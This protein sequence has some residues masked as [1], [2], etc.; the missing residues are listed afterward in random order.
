[1]RANPDG[2]ERGA[3][4]A[5]YKHPGSYVQPKPGRYGFSV[6]R[7]FWS[8]LVCQVC[9][10]WCRAWRQR[11]DPLSLDPPQ[12]LLGELLCT[13]CHRPWVSGDSWEQRDRAHQTAQDQRHISGRSRCVLR[14]LQGDWV[15]RRLQFPI[16]L[17]KLTD[18]LSPFTY[19]GAQGHL[20]DA[21]RVLGADVHCQVVLRDPR[22]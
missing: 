14:N 16:R 9:G 13:R 7:R 20:Q 5:F 21:L 18:W 6:L 15:W 3:L 12:F 22:R 11:G 8:L 19:E 1:M 4:Y 2:W 17:R 10:A